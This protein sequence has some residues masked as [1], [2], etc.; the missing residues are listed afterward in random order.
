MNELFVAVLHTAQIEAACVEYMEKRLY[1]PKASLSAKFDGE[2]INVTVREK[3]P[4]E[5]KV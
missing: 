2:F 5:K 1:V 4:E 3:P